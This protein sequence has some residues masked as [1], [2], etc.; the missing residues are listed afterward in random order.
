M[1]IISCLSVFL[2]TKNKRQKKQ[3]I[4][5]SYFGRVW[6][7]L[8]YQRPVDQIPQGIRRVKKPWL[9]LNIQRFQV[10]KTKQKAKTNDRNFFV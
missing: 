7:I 1:K 9:L 5:Y 3:S 6:K 2:Q 8:A 10:K 4:K